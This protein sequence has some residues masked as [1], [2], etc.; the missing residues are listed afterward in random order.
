MRASKEKKPWIT[1]P[2][3]A[4]R[5][6]VSAMTARTWIEKYHLG[7]KIGGR[8]RADPDKARE[9]LKPDSAHSGQGV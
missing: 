3:Q 2:E 6:N 4:Q 7:R 5:A 8:W 1:A 9:F